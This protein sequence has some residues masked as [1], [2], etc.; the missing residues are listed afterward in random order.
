M[1]VYSGGMNKELGGCESNVDT[2]WSEGEEIPDCL[3]E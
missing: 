1:D 2:G 3:E